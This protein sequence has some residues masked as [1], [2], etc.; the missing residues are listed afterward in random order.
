MGLILKFK[1]AKGRRLT[2]RDLGTSGNM[3]DKN[4]Y[5]IVGVVT[6]F[7]VGVSVGVLVGWRAHS[8]RNNWLK[9]KRDYYQQ[10][11]NETQETLEN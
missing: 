1:V 6:G 7:V 8:K 9:Q 2:S 4:T 11:V 10:K 3:A 5:L